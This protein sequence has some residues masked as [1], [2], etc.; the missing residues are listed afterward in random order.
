MLD[1]YIGSG[2]FCKTAS[3]Y[4]SEEGGVGQEAGEALVSQSKI[5][6]KPKI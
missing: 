2:S 1:I 6:A 3:L 4:V 5:L